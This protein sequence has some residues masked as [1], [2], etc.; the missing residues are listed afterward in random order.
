[1]KKC[2]WLI[3]VLFPLLSFGQFSLAVQA[4]ANQVTPHRSKQTLFSSVKGG[5]C[6]QAGVYT[7]YQ[8]HKLFVY[9]GLNVVQYHFSESEGDLFYNNS[10]YHPVYLQI[11]AGIGYKFTFHKNKSL[12]LYGGVQGLLGIAGK[13]QVP[14][15]IYCRTS[16]CPEL[17]GRL[18]SNIMFGKSSDYDYQSFAKT[19]ANLQVGTTVTLS[20]S[21]SAGVSYA[22]GI[23]DVGGSPYDVAG[24]THLRI[25]DVSVK[26]YLVH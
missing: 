24:T 6:W 4:G 11:P 13:L 19:A 15:Y 21:I 7:A 12:A 9:S 17:S 23:T 26:Y 25:W 20:Y 8:K 10:T 1:M 22:W 5:V 3:L 2:S 18:T 14:A 16:S